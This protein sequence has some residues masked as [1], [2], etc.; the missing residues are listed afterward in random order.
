M[1]NN[2]FHN[3]FHNSVYGSAFGPNSQ[4][5]N[6]YGEL[7][8]SEITLEELKSRFKETTEIQPDLFRQFSRILEQRLLLLGGI[9]GVVLINTS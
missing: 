6:H 9:L 8:F 5:H 7:E 1:N 3:S 2:N 4:V